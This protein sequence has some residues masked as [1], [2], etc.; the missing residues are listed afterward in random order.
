MAIVT[1]S[2]SPT[3]PIA[4][5]AVTLSCN[6]LA[7]QDGVTT[8][9]GTPPVPTQPISTIVLQPVGCLGEGNISTFQAKLTDALYQASTVV[10]DFIWVDAVAPEGLA[11]LMAGLQ[12][13][14]SLGKELSFCSADSETYATLQAQRLQQ[15]SHSLNQR[16]VVCRDDFSDFLSRR[17]QSLAVTPEKTPLPKPKP[18][19]IHPSCSLPIILPAASYAPMNWHT[20]HAAS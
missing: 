11:A 8:P 1:L 18:L 13:A 9:Q 15:R 7:P 14:E 2:S 17:G 19:V 16:T 6:P 5:S 12:L 10:I 20:D 4:S 3:L